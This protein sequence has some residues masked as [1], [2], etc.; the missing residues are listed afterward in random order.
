M[1][2]AYAHLAP[3]QPA[4]PPEISA[5]VL[6]VRT[7]YREHARFV[8]LSLQR[9]GI[10]PSDL[11]DIAQDVFM[12][13]H[14]RLDTFDRRARISTWLFGICMRVAANYRRRRRWTREVLSGGIEDERPSALA[15]ADDILVRREQRELAERAL[16]RLEVAKRATFVMFEIESLSCNEIAELMN[17]PVGTVYSRLHSARRQLE[18][19]LARDIARR[20]L[21]NS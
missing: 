6:E 20:G 10:H 17:V 7:I 8:W 12:I 1:K 11:D 14:R 18:K 5:D 15:A 21:G 4:A 3:I 2:H 19:N 9:L 16:N 13:V